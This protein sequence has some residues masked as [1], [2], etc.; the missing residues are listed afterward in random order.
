MNNMLYKRVFIGVFLALFM[1][2]LHANSAIYED[3]LEAPSEVILVKYSEGKSK[4]RADEYVELDLSKGFASVKDS[5]FKALKAQGKPPR[6]LYANITNKT[7]N[8]L[9]FVSGNDPEGLEHDGDIRFSAD[10][11]YD[12]F[13]TKWDSKAN[14]VY[15]YQ[16]FYINPPRSKTGYYY[17]VVDTNADQIG[18]RVYSAYLNE[19]NYKLSY[20]TGYAFKKDGSEISPL[21]ANRAGL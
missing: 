9:Y 10:E 17:F 7:I 18:D 5:Q 3:G 20:L 1:S 8:L 16:A 2:I 11:K 13:S 21:E 6:K 4:K 19:K 12:G 15:R 14:L